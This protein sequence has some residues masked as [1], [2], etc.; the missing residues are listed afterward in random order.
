MKPKWIL[1][2][3]CG[4]ALAGCGGDSGDVAPLRLGHSPPIGQMT[5]QQLR[6]LS[7]ECERYSP[8][9]SMRGRYDAEYCEAAIAAWG[10]SPLQIVTIHEQPA[11]AA[12]NP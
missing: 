2:V 9:N 6:S 3:F 5:A 10:D 11:P 1:L 8:S 4:A 12:E 7:M